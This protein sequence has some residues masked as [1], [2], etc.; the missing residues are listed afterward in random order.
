MKLVRLDHV[1]SVRFPEYSLL[2]QLLHLL[3]VDFLGVFLDCFVIL[4]AQHRVL[5]DP[6]PALA[7]KRNRLNQVEYKL[8]DLLG[9]VWAAVSLELERPVQNRRFVLDEVRRVFGWAFLVV[10]FSQYELKCELSREHEV[11][12]LSQRIQIGLN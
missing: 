2:A 11:Y 7:L 9:K 5:L 3:C 1:R 10:Y 6:L 12:A 8:L 4:E